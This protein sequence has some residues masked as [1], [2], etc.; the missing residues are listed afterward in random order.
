MDPEVQCLMAV[1]GLCCAGDT[2]LTGDAFLLTCFLPQL[3]FKLFLSS[4]I[5]I[6]LFL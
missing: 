4:G 1:L 2:V 6:V 3:A 5:G